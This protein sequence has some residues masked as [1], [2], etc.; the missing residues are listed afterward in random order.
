MNPCTLD[1]C[2]SQV[3]CSNVLYEEPPLTA[4]DDSNPCTNDGCGVSGEC[5]NVLVDV[6][7]QDACT[8]DQCDLATGDIS[9][10][11]LP[12]HDSNTCSLAGC[13]AGTCTY[14]YPDR[15]QG[16]CCE[17]KFLITPT[18]CRASKTS[19]TSLFATGPVATPKP[20]V[21]RPPEHQPRGRTLLWQHRNIVPAEQ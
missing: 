15:T 4:C 19:P 12:C 8:I 13:S 5:E 17:G 3:G 10:E 7:D 1:T 21:L 16:E 2:D 6:D 18:A 11:P 9:H 14:L 20:A